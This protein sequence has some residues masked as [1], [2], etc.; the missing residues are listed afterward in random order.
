MEDFRNGLFTS[1]SSFPSCK[2]LQVDTV[3]FVILS[4]STVP[5]IVVGPWQILHEWMNDLWS[6]LFWL[7]LS[8]AVENEGTVAEGRGEP[9]EQYGKELW[10]MDFK[11]LSSQAA[12]DKEFQN[13]SFL[14][15]GSLGGAVV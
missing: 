13:Q 1:G 6:F 5:G 7:V 15:E 10:T 14:D 9:A 2:L 8:Y 4:H 11:Y 3:L 12:D